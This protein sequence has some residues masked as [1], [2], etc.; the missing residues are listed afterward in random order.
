MRLIREVQPQVIVTYAPDGLSD[1]PEQIIINQITQR[2]FRAAG[3]SNTFPQHTRDGLYPYQPQKLYYAV[4]PQ[5]IISRWRLG[6]NGVPDERVT[7]ILDVSPYSEM[8][9]RAVYCQRH[10]AQDFAHWVRSQNGLEWNEEHF[11]LAASHMNRRPR[12]E[13][14][15]FAGLR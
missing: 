1:D 2:A 6:F 3:D 8:K 9:L 12:K 4:L 11:I 13:R 14:D 5:S 10:H 15:L 7:T